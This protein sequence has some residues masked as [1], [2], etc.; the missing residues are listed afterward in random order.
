MTGPW[1]IARL[2]DAAAFLDATEPL[3]GREPVL[4]N[5]LGSVSLAVVAGRRYDGAAWWLVRDG[6]GEVVGA[7]M[8]TPPFPTTVSPMPPEAAAALGDAL[9]REVAAGTL[10]PLTALGGPPAAAHAV[11]SRAYTPGEPVVVM[12]EVVR[13]L[14]QLVP[15]SGVAGR[16]RTATLDDVDLVRGW[17]TAFAAEAEVP[18]P[19]DDDAL[20]ARI[21]TGALRL[22]LDPRGRA[23][24]LAGH[25]PPVGTPA[26]TV[27][28][29]GPVW[30][31]PEHRRHG[32]AAALTGSLAA[33]LAADGATVMLFADAANATSNGVYA[34]LG[35]EVVDSWVELAPRP[36]HSG[37]AGGTVAR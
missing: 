28:R 19:R 25:A 10:A 15:A 27:V 14:G 16:E 36:W 7:A 13:V 31:P 17:L 9:H 34:R 11:A 33:E 30:T 5:V 6:G 21:G 22:W 18:D 32:Y 8:R 35:F 3:R 20:R 29:I 2:D 1:H 12:D 4:T 23:V 24:C 37:A 26:G